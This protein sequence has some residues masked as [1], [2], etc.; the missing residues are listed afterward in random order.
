MKRMANKFIK[1]HIAEYGLDG[2]NVTHN[3]LKY[4]ELGGSGILFFSKENHFVW[5][6][7]GESYINRR[8]SSCMY[9][10]D[11]LKQRNT[12]SI[13]SLDRS[14]VD[15]AEQM[16][17]HYPSFSVVNRGRLEDYAFVEACRDA[18]VTFDQTVLTYDGQLPYEINASVNFTLMDITAELLMNVADVVVPW[19][20][21]RSISIIQD[22]AIARAFDDQL[23]YPS[24]MH[25]VNHNHDGEKSCGPANWA[26]C[27]EE[28]DTA[29]V[30]YDWLEDGKTHVTPNLATWSPELMASQLNDHEFK[31]WIAGPGRTAPNSSDAMEDMWQRVSPFPLQ[32]YKLPDWWDDVQG[33]ID[34][35]HDKGKCNEK[36]FTPLHRLLDR[37]DV[38]YPIG[39]ADESYGTV[40]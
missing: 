38:S 13:L 5:G 26:L 15:I 12:G 6:Y 30:R 23:V 32:S 1:K 20:R 14:L 24:R 17:S 4:P 36:W 11:Y 34:S 3:D 25:L 18:G 9:F 40:Y 16:N 33:H 35:I 37:L 29:L 2:S 39:V 28:E 22:I 8:S 27:D 31:K 21:T 10:T 7:N 19:L